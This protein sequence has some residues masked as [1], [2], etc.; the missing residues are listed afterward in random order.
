MLVVPIEFSL[1]LREWRENA[2]QLSSVLEEAAHDL[3]G[4]FATVIEL[5]I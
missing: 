3:E 5:E 2:P 4:L 1:C